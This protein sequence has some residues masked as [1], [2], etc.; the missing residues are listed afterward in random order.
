M[1]VRL[2]L[3]AVLFLAFVG[4]A[5]LKVKDPS[6]RR[7]SPNHID[8]SR[9]LVA[10]V[11]D[12]ESLEIIRDVHT[13]LRSIRVFG[14]SLN[15][16]T[17]VV[18]VPVASSGATVIPNGVENLSALLGA[19]GV[20]LAFIP[21]V[22]S[23]RSKT[24]LKFAAMREFSAARGFDYLL[25]LDADSF[26]LRDPVP[27]LF[28]HPLSG[29][30]QCAP[31]LYSYMVRYPEVNETRIVKNRKLA[32]FRLAGSG[33]MAPHGTCNTGVL[34]FDR[35]SLAAFLAALPAAEAEVEA[36]GLALWPGDRF[37]DS[38]LFVAAINRAA[39]HVEPFPQGYQ[40][41]Y[42]AFFEQEMMQGDLPYTQIPAIAQFISDTEFFCF[43]TGTGTGTGTG[44]DS[45]SFGDQQAQ[46][47]SGSTTL[48]QN[49]TSCLCKYV[50][51]RAPKSGGSLLQGSLEHLLS[52]ARR[53]GE[54]SCRM[55]AGAIPLPQR[56]A[57]L[58]PALKQL[59]EQRRRVQEQESSS[60]MSVVGGSLASDPGADPSTAP[61]TGAGADPGQNHKAATNPHCALIKPPALG[62]V[63]HVPLARSVVPLDMELCCAGP[64]SLWR[65]NRQL[66]IAVNITVQHIEARAAGGPGAVDS[67]Q[68][69]WLL[70][71][72]A[73]VEIPPQG[74]VW[75]QTAPVGEAIVGQQEQ[76]SSWCFS[77][78]SFVSR[79]GVDA[80]A[81]GDSLRDMD[82]FL[83]SLSPALL[84]GA[85]GSGLSSDSDGH[86]LGSERQV[87]KTL[88]VPRPVPVTVIVDELSSHGLTGPVAASPASPQNRHSRNPAAASDVAQPL[89]RVPR[90]DEGW[91][92]TLA[93]QPLRNRMPLSSQLQLAS[94]LG[95]QGI[96][97]GASGVAVC[98][99]THRGVEVV[100][101]MLSSWMGLQVTVLLLRT[102]T[103]PAVPSSEG[104]SERKRGWSE[105]AADAAGSENTTQDPAP[106]SAL[107]LLAVDLGKSCASRA[108]RCVLVAQPSDA[109][110]FAWAL[111]SP[112]GS[113]GWVYL[114]VFESLADYSASL[115]AWFHALT[116]GGVLM[117]SRFE[118]PSRTARQR[119][120]SQHH[121]S[122]PPLDQQRQQGQ[123]QGQGQTRESRLHV[124]NLDLPQLDARDG[125]RLAVEDFS[126]SLQL[127]PLVTY[128]DAAGQCGSS[129]GQPHAHECLAAFYFVKDFRSS[130]A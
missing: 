103:S 12:L 1:V 102:P 121:P 117:G 126:D 25:W 54:D 19:Y 35:T 8:P 32:P 128:S 2:L 108:S 34:F 81:A 72:S 33:E 30:V 96:E 4:G 28:I 77:W 114:D 20:E 44:T 89:E 71:G 42:M 95:A 91:A 116:P 94:F 86:K 67:Q 124:R 31:E 14:A 107:Q 39:I 85:E 113:L 22:E 61:G 110:T 6:R 74:M 5:L 87:D 23:G 101:S 90:L 52:E 88:H 37:M 57:E 78:L 15:K 122:H 62:S 73:L 18:C 93:S 119:H 99:D 115:E 63:L 92:H 26:I 41:N 83:V 79:D 9:L 104:E 75:M 3:L 65:Q 11:L 43:V 27:L 58:S 56:A 10:T 36:A 105:T 97:I 76:H 29:M 100:R 45:P 127:A 40:L 123:G 13:L 84:I 55:L 112:P 51:Q 38:L 68:G 129:P 60:L 120:H 130:W 49:E 98:C 70:Q 125:V 47:A 64:S 7:S 106:M 80:G 59:W 53:V 16:A 109:K 66:A 48:G 118:A 46:A 17:I 50:N 21:Q 69:P 111:S 24:Q 82:R